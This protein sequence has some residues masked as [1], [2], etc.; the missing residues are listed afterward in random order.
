M[1]KPLR[2]VS[3]LCAAVAQQVHPEAKFRKRHRT[4]LTVIQWRTGDKGDCLR[5]SREAGAEWKKPPLLAAFSDLWRFG[6]M[7]VAVAPKPMG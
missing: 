5:W 3:P 2:E 6:D 1:P 7:R 4:D